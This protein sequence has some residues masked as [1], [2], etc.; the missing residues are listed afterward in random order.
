V[1][2]VDN[3][4]ELSTYNYVG[5]EYRLVIDPNEPDTALSY[6]V[7][8]E[9]S[10]P[11]YAPERFT[12]T[13]ATEM[14]SDTGRLDDYIESMLYIRYNYFHGFGQEIES[15]SNSPLVPGYTVL[16]AHSEER[17][18]WVEPFED[19]ASDEHNVVYIRYEE[20][21]DGEYWKVD[22]WEIIDNYDA[23]R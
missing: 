15:Y 8:A 7:H 10:E 1:K 14:Y 5:D 21:P 13:D 6:D 3:T 17:L 11:G 2:K 4:V 23:E 16:E 22:K 20:V 12:R 9:A 19:M 18:V